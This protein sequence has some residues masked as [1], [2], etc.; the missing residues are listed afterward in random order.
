M[1]DPQDA[2]SRRSISAKGLDGQTR[3]EQLSPLIT[4]KNIHDGSVASLEY[5][6]LAAEILGEHVATMDAILAK[7]LHSILSADQREKLEAARAE[8]LSKKVNAQRAV[9]LNG[10]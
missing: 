3:L 6:R 2:T 8:F 10:K 7:P 5:S 1:Y 9:D 4:K